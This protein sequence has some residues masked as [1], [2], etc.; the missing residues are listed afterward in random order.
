MFTTITM[1]I[2]TIVSTLTVQHVENENSDTPAKCVII[3]KNRSVRATVPKI[4]NYEKGH[5]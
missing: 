3:I 5:S 1:L 4:I 2:G